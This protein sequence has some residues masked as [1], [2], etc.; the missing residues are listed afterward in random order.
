[1]GNG[2]SEC[3]LAHSFATTLAFSGRLRSTAIH[4]GGNCRLTAAQE[5]A[6]LLYAHLKK[7][8]EAVQLPFA[9]TGKLN[10]AILELLPHAHREA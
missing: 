8:C 9:Q 6:K 5:R 2:I 10:T 3:F 1:M 7:L 4:R